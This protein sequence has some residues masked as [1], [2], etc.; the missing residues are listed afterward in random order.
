MTGLDPTLS[1]YDNKDYRRFLPAHLQFL[2]RL[3]QLSSQSINDSVY[4]F[5]SSSFITAKTLTENTV[6]SRIDSLIQQNKLNAP[7]VW[8]DLLFLVQAVNHG[9]AIISAYGTNFVYKL[10]I[11]IGPQVANTW[12]EAVIYDNECSCALN[13]T[14]TTGANF[15]NNNSYEIISIKGFKMGCT[16]SESFLQ[17]T[18][19]CFYDPLCINLIQEQTNYNS[20]INTTV[21]TSPL[22]LTASRF[23][24][25][26]PVEGLINELFVED[27]STMINYS[28]YFE[29]CSPSA[30]SYTYTQQLNSIYTVTFLLSIYGGLTI[31]L[32]WV[33]PR[34]VRLFTKIYECRKKRTN[35]VQHTPSINVVTVEINNTISSPANVQGTI[36][37]RD[38]LPMVSTPQYGYFIQY[39]S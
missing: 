33:C 31:I 2:S 24:I 19:E 9:N 32:K 30:C 12:T 28:S 34:I 6:K 35:R 11:L 1:I 36:H 26:T 13:A 18:L 5:L 16:P 29:H 39:Q 17:S 7:K 10:P 25:N 37:D 15:I 20:S 4:Q 14:C 8:T 27:W 23:P 21:T 3:C 22:S 38:L